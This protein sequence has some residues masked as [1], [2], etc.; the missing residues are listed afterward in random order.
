MENRS[1]LRRIIFNLTIP[2]WYLVLFVLMFIDIIAGLLDYIFHTRLRAPKITVEEFECFVE[3]YVHPGS[4]NE[5][6]LTFLQL[7]DLPYSEMIQYKGD[8]MN[9][10]LIKKYGFEPGSELIRGQMCTSVEKV[11]GSLLG[12]NDIWV[13]FYF[14]DR[15]RLVT[16]TAEVVSVGF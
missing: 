14:N 9:S 15:N 8:V 11:G 1:P 6:V 13:C 7:F 12:R 16:Y 4:T 3:T 5:E 10:Y 2:F